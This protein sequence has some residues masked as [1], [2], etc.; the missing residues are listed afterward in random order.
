M[1]GGRWVGRGDKNGADG[2]AVEAMRALISTVSMKGVVV[3]GEG[4]KDDAPMLYNGEEVGDGNGP[5]VRRRGRP[6]RRHDADRQGPVQRGRRC[7]RWPTAARCTTR[8]RSSTWTSSSPAPRPPTSSTSRLPVA[9]NISGSPRP[10]RTT[11]EDV[12]VVMLDRPR[13]EKLA[14]EVRDAGARHQVHLRRRRRRRDHG[15]PRRH[16][17]R[18]AARHRRHARGHHRRL[19]H[20]VPRRRHPGPALAAGRRRAPAGPRRR[21][22]PRPGALDR[23]PRDR[24]QLL[25]RRRPASPTASC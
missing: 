25:L 15:G 20:Q 2:A 14:A 23:R 3:I 12:T 8:A 1:A 6:D 9:E 18:P 7:W 10:R 5:E 17:H 22:R 4:E 19:R 24:R 21:P 16:R 11:V 13:H